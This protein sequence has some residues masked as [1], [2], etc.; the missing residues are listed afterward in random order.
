MILESYYW[1]ESLLDCANN[2]ERYSKLK[3]IKPKDLV[4]IE[5]D[6]FISFYSIRKLMDTPK[7]S[8]STRELKINL[9]WSPNLRNVTM[10]N[11]HKMNELYDLD[12]I[13]VETKNL[14][15]LC[16]QFVH[17]YIFE[18]VIE[19]GV[20]LSFCY[21]TSDR[22]K[23]KKIFFITVEMLVH[24]LNLVGNDYP[25]KLKITR[26]SKTGELLTEVL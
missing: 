9:N 14:R 24:I 18:V 10:L 8:D 6:I 11:S 26:D 12:D 17:S 7:I 5:K 21:F 22:D 20:G 3:D 1:K 4:E 13:R 19:N 2:L 25:S 16:N 23:N 15:F